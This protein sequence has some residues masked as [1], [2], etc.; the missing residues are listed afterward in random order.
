MNSSC[1]ISL[2]FVIL[3]VTAQHL[4]MIGV[5]VVTW[6]T[7][8]PWMMR[9]FFSFLSPPLQYTWSGLEDDAVV[10]LLLLKA[11]LL[12]LVAKGMETKLS[13]TFL[14]HPLQQLYTASSPLSWRPR[15]YWW[16]W[17]WSCFRVT[18]RERS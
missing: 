11:T 17:R 4:W 16:W 8:L 6:L 12:S 2:G 14:S 13:F 15:R 18:S 5:L 7:L 10:L 9:M 3:M 1:S